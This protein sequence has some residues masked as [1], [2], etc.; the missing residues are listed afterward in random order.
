MRSGQPT[1]T[2]AKTNGRFVFMIQYGYQFCS[3]S[4]FF[5]DAF[6]KQVSKRMKVCYLRF[7]FGPVN[8]TEDQHPALISI[9]HVFSLFTAAFFQ[10][11][12]RITD[13][14]A[15]KVN[16]IWLDNACIEN[17]RPIQLFIS[18]SLDATQTGRVEII[19]LFRKI[20]KIPVMIS[21]IFW[22]KYGEVLKYYEQKIEFRRIHV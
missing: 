22:Y 14:L 20:M 4:Y 8:N 10:W 7:I 17:S 18:T 21:S 19:Q 12:Q 3:S 9:Y 13:I 11:Q 5:V 15:G 6:E 1:R 2:R 16:S